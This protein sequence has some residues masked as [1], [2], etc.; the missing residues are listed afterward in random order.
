MKDLMTKKYDSPQSLH[1]K[2]ISTEKRMKQR[3]GHRASDVV[4]H[5]NQTISHTLDGQD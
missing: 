5:V 1:Q 3:F 2:L 4:A